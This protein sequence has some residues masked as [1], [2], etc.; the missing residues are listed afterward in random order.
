M[1]VTDIRYRNPLNVRASANAPASPMTAPVDASA[2]PSRTT[3]PSTCARLALHG[4]LCRLPAGMVRTG[5]GTWMIRAKTQAD[6]EAGED[7]VARS[8]LAHEAP[9]R[10]G[11]EGA[12]GQWAFADGGRAHEEILRGLAGQSNCSTLPCP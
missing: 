2:C 7:L 1:S 8:R 11:H 12:G 10:T 6:D 9:P 3:M 4:T 5:R